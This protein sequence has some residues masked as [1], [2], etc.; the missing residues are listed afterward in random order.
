MN[1]FPLTVRTPVFPPLPV[2]EGGFACIACDAW[3]RRGQGGSPPRHYNT[4][5]VDDLLMLRV[6]DIVARNAWL[7][8][9]WPDVHAPSMPEVMETFGFKFSG[10]G[11]A[12]IKILR[13][14]GRRPGLISTA[15]IETALHKGTGQKTRKNSET[16]WLGGRGSPKILSHSVWELI[17][18]PVRE[19]S[20]K[21]N[22]FF[23][24]AE[25]F[26]QGPRIDL[27]GRQSRNG[28]TV[29]GDQA[30]MFDASAADVFPFVPSEVPP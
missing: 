22:E 14:L 29:N 11:F 23:A 6:R 15:D 20:R 2:V 19:H 10:K 28:W 24:R 17:V 5:S 12:W 4:F 3:S 7:L 16:A 30:R 26:C 18:A 9:W 8:L 25:Q 21:P 13:S 27:F 1:D